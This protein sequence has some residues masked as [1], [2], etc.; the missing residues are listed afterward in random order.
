[1]RAY[2]AQGSP[3]TTRATGCFQRWRGTPL[4]IHNVWDPKK[5]RPVSFNGDPVNHQ[6]VHG[7]GT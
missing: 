3:K 5:A 1:M 2:I 6:E 7:A 4:R